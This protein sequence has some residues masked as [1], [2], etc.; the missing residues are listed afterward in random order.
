MNWGSVLPAYPSFVYLLRQKKKSVVIFNTTNNK[1]ISFFNEQT[2]PHISEGHHAVVSLKMN[3]L[4][5]TKAN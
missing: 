3:K 2:A 1:D 4:K 5:K